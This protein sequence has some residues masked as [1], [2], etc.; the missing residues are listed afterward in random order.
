[1]TIYMCPYEV[2]IRIFE[3]K[4]FSLCDVCDV[5]AADDLITSFTDK[6]SNIKSWSN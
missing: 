5:V 2:D 4:L 1:M 3:V 6:L